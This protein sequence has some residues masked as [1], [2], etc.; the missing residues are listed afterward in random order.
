MAKKT[1]FLDALDQHTESLKGSYDEVAR[2]IAAKNGEIDAA[3]Q[4]RHAAL[5][6]HVAALLPN[7]E[8]AAF[9][10]TSRV[11]PGFSSATKARR[12]LAETR[13][14]YQAALEQLLAWYDP[15]TYDGCK[16]KVSHELQDETENRA[17]IYTELD[18]LRAIHG[19]E[20]LVERGY[21]TPKYRSRWW[22]RQFYRDWQAADAAVAES[23][24]VD[25]E[26]L[27]DKYL[28]L[29]VTLTTLDASVRALLND[30]VV[31]DANQ[32]SY[33]TLTKAIA[34]A[35]ATVLEQFQVK[36]KSKLDSMDDLPIELS[37]IISHQR[38]ITALQAQVGQLQAS[39][40]KLSEQLTGLLQMRDQASRSR[41]STVPNEYVTA[42]RG[43]RVSSSSGG[44]SRSHGGPT[45][46][47][48]VY[49]NDY[50]LLDAM[51]Y[52]QMSD[53][54]GRESHH[55]HGGGG[56]GYGS[57]RPSDSYIESAQRAASRDTSGRS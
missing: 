9:A 42:L 53:Y 39:R 31:L 46:V 23:G 8:E 27:A 29:K 44:R 12:L 33:N 36:L 4:Q 49:G 14:G 35:P 45:S 26:T 43:A 13:S 20:S 24:K 38:R 55:H 6:E 11:V 50:S 28:I 48:H 5:D 47:V 17:A 10:A 34:N 16:A 40:I 51:V 2:E 15:K 41:A 19:L 25:W 30:L 56:S 1:E 18:R 57:E 32:N 22:Q 21:G 52:M 54:F 7:L 37:D 3:R